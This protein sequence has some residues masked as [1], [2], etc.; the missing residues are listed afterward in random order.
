MLAEAARL[1]GGIATQNRG[2]IGGN[3]VN[4]SPAAD[5][6]PA[7]LAYDAEVE[8]ISLRGSRWISYSQFHKGYKQMDLAPRRTARAHPPAEALRG[9]ASL[10]SQGGN[11]PGAGDLESLFR[12]GQTRRRDAHRAGQ[13]RARCL[14]CFSDDLTSEI[15][16]ID[17]IRSTARYRLR[18]AQNLLDEFLRQHDSTSRR[19]VTDGA[20]IP[21]AIQIENGKIAAV[22]RF[23]ESDGPVF[24]GVILPGLVDTH[25]HIN[26]PG[27]TDWEGFETATRAAAA[28]G[29]TT[30][31]EMPLNSIPATT[32]VAGVS[33]KSRCCPRKTVGRHWLLGWRRA[34]EYSRT[35]AALGG[36]RL[37]LQVFSRAFGRRRVR[38]CIRS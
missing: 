30:L 8:L 34:R 19:V 26:E 5:T 32:N 33:R 22:R 12:R 6:P 3:I 20:M 23:D 31:I 15:S 28:G 24:E 37:W 25:V 11:T 16:P 14:S 2:T 29:V 36:G 4:A 18:V 17:D 35:R 1:T 27:R 7:L 21:A 38:T 13:R 9:L 10:L